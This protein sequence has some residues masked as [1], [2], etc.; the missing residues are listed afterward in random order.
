VA[1]DFCVFHRKEFFIEYF[2]S[3]AGRWV[4]GVGAQRNVLQ[5]NISGHIALA[6]ISGLRNSMLSFQTDESARPE[7]KAV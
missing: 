4:K 1:P 3:R 6:S 7:E 2:I 5:G